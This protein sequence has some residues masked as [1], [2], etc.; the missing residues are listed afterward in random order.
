M[1][2]NDFAK[3]NQI[4]VREN[5][6]SWM[7]KSIKRLLNRKD[8]IDKLLKI[9]ET[10]GYGQANVEFYHFKDTPTRKALEKEGRRLRKIAMQYFPKRLISP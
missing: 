5:V 3:E 7:P 4:H 10:L 2:K 8:S 9:Y 1:R 6:K